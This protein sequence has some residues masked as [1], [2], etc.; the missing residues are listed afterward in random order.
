MATRS[1]KLSDLL[2][3]K[4]LKRLQPILARIA[5]GDLDLREG[6][7]E[8]MKV[9]APHKEDLLAKGVLDEYLAWYLVNLA[10]RGAPPQD[11]PTRN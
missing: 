6:K 10:T 5:A 9:L 2:P 1:E 4:A 7:D 8:I 3:R 11:F